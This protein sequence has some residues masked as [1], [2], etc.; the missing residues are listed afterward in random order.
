MEV[1]SNILKS[2]FHAYTEVDWAPGVID[3]YVNNSYS[4]SMKTV[5]FIGFMKLLTVI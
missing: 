2:L 1:A 5:M 4:Y 3:S